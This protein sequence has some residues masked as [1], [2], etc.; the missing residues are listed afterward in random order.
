MIVVDD[1]ERI[2][3]R[4]ARTRNRSSRYQAQLRDDGTLLLVPVDDY[5]GEPVITG[6]VGFTVEARHD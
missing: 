4:W 6:S 3:L 1:W 2:S 5:T